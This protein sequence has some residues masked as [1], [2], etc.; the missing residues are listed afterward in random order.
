MNNKDLQ[1]FLNQ[2]ELMQESALWL[3]DEIENEISKIPSERKITDEEYK[4]LQ[5]LYN[6]LE[7][8]AKMYDNFY[9]KYKKFFK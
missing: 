1:D 5:I 2:H 4:K 6:R 3:I 9:L 7:Y 8:E